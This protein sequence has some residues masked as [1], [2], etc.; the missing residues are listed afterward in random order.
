[1]LEAI[2]AFFG[3]KFGMSLLG[4]LGGALAKMGYDYVKKTETKKDDKAVEVFANVTKEV[5]DSYD[6]GKTEDVL[7]DILKK[8][9]IMDEDTKIIEEKVKKEIE[10]K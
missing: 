1:M 9:E 6:F 10:K 3:T 8:S 5:L 2:L 4:L 7:R